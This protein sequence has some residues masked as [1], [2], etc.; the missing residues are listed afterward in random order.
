MA[1][2]AAAVA[3]AAAAAAVV[4]GG[5][6]TLLVVFCC[7]EYTIS[8]YDSQAMEHRYVIRN[9]A[10]FFFV[11]GWVPYYNGLMRLI[12]YWG[13]VSSIPAEYS[14]TRVFHLYL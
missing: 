7:L 3:A 2:A 11:R 14:P 1:V 6:H 4:A 8:V 12:S 5:T 10:L 13:I 9:K